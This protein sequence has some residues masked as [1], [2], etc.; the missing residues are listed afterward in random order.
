MQ[1]ETSYARGVYDLCRK[2][3]ILFISDEVRQGAGKTGKFLSYY[4]LGEDC[5]PDIVTMGK[6][7]TGGFYPQSFILGTADVMSLVGTYESAST[8]AYSPLGIAAARAALEVIDNENL[9]HRA[10]HLGK[11]FA[12]I[13]DSWDHPLVD[14]LSVRGAD[15]AL[16]L[17]G[18]SGR[19]VTALCLHKGLL[20]YPRANALRMSFAMV[21]TDE[22]LERGASIIE[23]SLNTL[24]DYDSVP[25]E[26][27]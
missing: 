9:V 27:C 4:H 10:T 17:K 6:S 26:L 15:V 18:V 8:F 16:Y 3:N 2:Y 12:D 5:K 14:Y 22:E 24:N 25:G 21:M 11:R 13:V 23:E 20:L 19:R 1:E 7:I